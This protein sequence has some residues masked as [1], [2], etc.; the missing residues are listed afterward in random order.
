MHTETVG[1]ERSAGHRKLLNGVTEEL[2]EEEQ[3]TEEA[4]VQGTS[5]RKDAF[6]LMLS[7]IK[8]MPS[9]GHVVTPFQLAGQQASPAAATMQLDPFSNPCYAVQHAWSQ[10]HNAHKH[11]HHT[12]MQKC[13]RQHADDAACTKNHPDLAGEE[14]PGPVKKER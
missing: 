9:P 6:D 5:G 11:N 10:C 2:N 3:T 7:H 8:V 14:S 4:V 12:V 13:A 1:L